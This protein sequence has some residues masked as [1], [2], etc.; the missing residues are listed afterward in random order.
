VKDEIIELDWENDEKPITELARFKKAV[1]ICLTER[2]AMIVKLYCGFTE[3]G[4]C[5]IEEIATETGRPKER[6]E[7]ILRKA[8]RACGPRRRMSEK[9]R[10]FLEE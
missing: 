7:Q 5:S 3:R 9:L 4:R 2:E 8:Y 6:I 1:E 10:K